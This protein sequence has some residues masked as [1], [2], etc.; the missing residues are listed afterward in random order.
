[1]CTVHSLAISYTS[2]PAHK[3]LISQSHGNRSINLVLRNVEDKLVER[4][5]I[6]HKIVDRK[7]TVINN[8]L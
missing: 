2:L 7:A 5:A 4:K 1:M 3:H 6:V 8:H